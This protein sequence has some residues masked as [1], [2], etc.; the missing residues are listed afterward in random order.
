M[1]KRLDPK[2]RKAQLIDAALQVAE[3]H[4]YA[5]M[6]REDI[7]NHAEVSEGLISLYF[8]TMPQLRR[9]VIR[10]SIR[11]RNL[12]VLAQGL[13]NRDPHALKAPKEIRQAAFASLMGS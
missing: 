7:A 5:N 3:T 8:N 4:G 9:A 1:K 11:Q 10:H 13:V 6:R 2:V 12:T